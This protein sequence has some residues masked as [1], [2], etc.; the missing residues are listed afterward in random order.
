ML[1]AIFRDT[2]ANAVG[3]FR[4][5]NILWHFLAVAL[6]ALLVLSGTDWGFYESTR[7]DFLRPLV[8]AAGIG[9]FL[10]PVLLPIALYVVGVVRKDKRLQYTGAAVAQAVILALVISS[11]YKVF[12]GRVQPGF[13]GAVGGT[14]IS[15]EFQFGILRN[16]VFWGWPSSHATV[17]FALAASL[18]RLY[19]TKPVIVLTYTYAI[20]VAIGAAIGFHWL[21]DVVAGSIIGSLVG[22]V[23]AKSFSGKS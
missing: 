16:G 21:S 3:V 13:F 15:K 12:T 14:D 11:F 6:T 2:L 23:V 7:A 10:V 18:T 22:A 20:I 5:R 4:G 19:R 1:K 8:F 9:G 17:A